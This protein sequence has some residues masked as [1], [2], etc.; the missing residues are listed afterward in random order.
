MA[1]DGTLRVEL[2]NVNPN[3]RSLA[4]AARMQF[5]QEDLPVLLF[6][7]GT[8]GGNLL[9]TAA[10]IYCRVLFL[11]TAGLCLSTVLGFPVAS[12]VCLSLFVVATLSGFIG[13]A[14]QEM[15]EYRNI[16]DPFVMV[17][18]L[19]KPLAQAVLW[20]V[21]KF[22]LFNPVPTLVAGRAVT[23]IWVLD[24]IA[25]LVLIRGTILALAAFV[26]LQRREL[27]D[28]SIS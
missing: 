2:I 9:R 20:I 19:I 26:L 18:W 28:A 4:N 22:S 16:D 8:F 24:S 12:L 6:H 14:L 11:L 3:L 7:L 17:S 15:P 21:P 23:L 25:R 13:E 1:G 27:G 5:E 10:I